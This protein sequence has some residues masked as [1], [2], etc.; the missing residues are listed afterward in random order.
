MAYDSARD[1]VFVDNFESASVSVIS[2]TNN[3]VVANIT[4]FSS[5]FGIAYD[6]A[7]GEV[8]VT[9]NGA[10]TVSVISDSNNVVVATVTLE[11]TP[12]GVAYDPAR[13]E[14]FVVNDGDSADIIYDGSSTSSATSSA[15][16][17]LSSAVG[18][19]KIRYRPGCCG[20]RCFQWLRLR[21]QLQHPQ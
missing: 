20:R 1:E 18:S 4:G 15:S 21:G 11:V 5:P 12:L 8:F 3:E 9:N 14:L 16:A 17:S 10:G 6:S 7:R 2:A 13:G 19:V